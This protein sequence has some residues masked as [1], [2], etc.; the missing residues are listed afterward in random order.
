MFRRAIARRPVVLNRKLG[1]HSNAPTIA[2]A[3]SSGLFHLTRVTVS[4][5][6]NKGKKMRIL[7][8]YDQQFRIEIPFANLELM[9][10]L[11]NQLASEFR[12][13]RRKNFEVTFSPSISIL[14]PLNKI[15]EGE[16]Q[17]AAEEHRAKE[18]EGEKGRGEKRKKKRPSGKK[19]N[20]RRR[21][22]SSE[23]DVDVAGTGETELRILSKKEAAKLAN[24]LQQCNKKEAL[25][26]LKNWLATRG[27]KRD[28][29]QHLL[30]LANIVGVEDVGSEKRFRLAFLRDALLNF[31]A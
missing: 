13:W 23:I 6:S 11:D 8:P 30:E 15:A 21:T 17:K 24:R 5:A 22:T 1:E 14:I 12:D 18:S 27:M 16:G 31:N 7:P 20:K 26:H 4:K 2:E 19:S 10:R 9:A 29:W 25:Q 28:Q 3:E